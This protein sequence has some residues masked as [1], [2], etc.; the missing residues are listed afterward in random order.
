MKTEV[1][2]LSDGRRVKY[3]LKKRE[4][5]P[6]FLIV[7][8]GPDGKRKERSA[9]EANRKRA[10]ESAVTLIVQEYEPKVYHRDIAW[11]DAIA[12]LE[13]VMRAANLRP[14]T[15]STYK[16]AIQTLR[17]VFPAAPG[18]SSI[19]PAMAKQYKGA[20]M[21]SGHSPH[22]VKGDLMELK[23]AF[24]KWWGDECGILEVN[25]FADVD[26]P[27]VDKLEPR[28]IAP[29]ERDIFTAWLSGRWGGWRLPLLFLE[30][31]ASIGCRIRELAALPICNLK[32]GRVTFEAV[33]AK[34]RKTRRC[35]LPAHLFEEVRSIAGPVFVFERFPDQLRDLLMDRGRPHHAKCVKFPFDPGCL[36]NWLQDR[37][38]EF[39]KSHSEIPRFKLHNLRGTAMSRAKE[40]GVSYDEAAIAFGCHAETMRKHYVKLDETAISDA[41][42]DRVQRD[43]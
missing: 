36:V 22:T 6:Y 4:R 40:A 13:K 14:N 29:V 39:R 43:D 21:E 34:G 7:F 27:K 20:R 31:K 42:M 19:T 37:L 41:V 12:M 3:S 17:V 35:K 9:E 24:G 11:D 30:V 38:V 2:V 32:D 26:P 8:T 16:W 25:P 18:P 15:I 23:T 28:I 1:C 33:T 10:R 5:D